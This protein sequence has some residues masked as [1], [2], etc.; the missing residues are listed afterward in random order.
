MPLSKRCTGDQTTVEILASFEV[1]ERIIGYDK[2]FPSR[3]SSEI[4]SANVVGVVK[5]L[6]NLFT[7][8]CRNKYLQKLYLAHRAPT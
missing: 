4:W 2:I 3:S 6:Y 8:Y 7:V 1:R 5:L